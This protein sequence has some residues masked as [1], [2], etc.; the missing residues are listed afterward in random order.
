MKKIIG[1]AYFNFS[2]I[3]IATAALGESLAKLESLKQSPN[4][5]WVSDFFI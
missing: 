4:D 5:D 2:E 3:D 1:Y